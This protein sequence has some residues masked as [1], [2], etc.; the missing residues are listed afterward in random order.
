MKIALFDQVNETHV[1][2]AFAQALEALGH[3]VLETGA[4]WR[5]HRLPSLAQDAAAID[6]AL[7]TVLS[8]GCDALFNFRA[9]ALDPARVSRLRAAGVATAVWLPD[10]PVLYDVTYRH[11]VD[12]YDHVLHCGA[13][14]V[15]AFY[16]SRGH[17]PG[18][19]FPFWLDPARWPHAWDPDR[20]QRE[21]VFLGNLHGPAKQGRYQRLAPARGR[22]SLYGICPHDPL[23]LHAGELHGID[24]MLAVLPLFR[25]GLNLPQRFAEYA[26]S[27]YDF[28]G[29]AALG[30]FDLPSRVVQYAAL[31]LP[32]ITLDE[33]PPS[34]S[35]PC[36]LHAEDIEAA[37]RLSD[38]LAADPDAARA[39]SLRARVDVESNFS[40]ISRARLLAALLSGELDPGA[41]L[42]EARATCYRN[43]P[44]NPP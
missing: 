34:D 5:G 9:S 18:V 17:R 31:G 8:A 29:L 23:G 14:S 24:A 30:T 10:D 25:A 13:E 12:A 7:E 28:P 44:G 22:I 38:Q 32:V 26:G 43:F 42:P 15:L 3:E 6:A 36:S 41:M 37:L 19:N 35:F 40:A 1:C 20:V 21:L 33:R 11:V 2:H 4:V 27:G 16:A 39:L